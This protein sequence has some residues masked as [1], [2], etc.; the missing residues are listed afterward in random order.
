MT[1]A[2]K[3]ETRNPEPGSTPD[4]RLIVFSDDWGRHP[5]SCQH[6]VGHLLDHL[7]VTW[8]NTIGMR[9]PTLA[10]SDIKRGAQKLAA[11]GT[12]RSTAEGHDL[13]A[14]LTI[15][16]PA[17]Y[18]GFRRPWQ[19]KINARR[20]IKSVHNSIGVRGLSK[21]TQ[22]RVL[23]TTLPI[24]ADLHDRLDIDRWVYY[25]VDDFS[26]WPGL[27]GDVM[28]EMEEELLRHC[29]ATIAVSETIRV[30]LSEL[31]ASP[32]T[33]THGIDLGHWEDAGAPSAKPQAAGDWWP[34]GDGPI[35]LFWGLIDARLDADWCL[36]LADRLAEPGVDG[37]LVLAGPAQSPD[38]RVT[39]HARVMTPG[40]VDY[41]DL[42]ILAAEAHVLVMPYA[43]LPVTQAMQPLK[44][45]E[46]LA[47]G[48]PA[49]VRALPSTR[50]WADAVD[51]VDNPGT[52]I[53]TVL[54]RAGGG[55]PESQTQA[56]R[57]LTDETWKSKAQQ[58]EQVL[59]GM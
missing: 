3:P 29:D 36:A 19:R 30:R 6:L 11:M 33:L 52:F 22:P 23:V 38:E 13:P 16:E 35:V 27:D 14:N 7:Q 32:V 42:P 40:P 51:V 15:V 20:M 53:D 46:Y 24:A 18:P 43:D 8:V 49:V 34:K 17:M 12:S 44:F 21:K 26:V 31:G 54:K 48:R 28:L 10:W 1:E 45:K 37:W 4:A 57:R 59:F 56:R 50:E 39:G 41:S 58:F 25:C 2:P 47:T 5:S 55:I 9:R